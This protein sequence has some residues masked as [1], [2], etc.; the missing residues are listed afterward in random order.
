MSFD[1]HFIF[2]VLPIQDKM[3]T[4]QLYIFDQSLDALILWHVFEQ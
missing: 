2:L 3:K 4:L 1:I